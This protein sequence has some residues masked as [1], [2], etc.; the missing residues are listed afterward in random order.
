MMDLF[1]GKRI[2][3]SAIIKE[4]AESFAL[5]SNDSK[6]LN[7]LDTDYARI[8]SKEYYET[9]IDNNAQDESIIEYGIRTLDDDK[10][11]GFIMLHSIEWNNRKAIM[12]VG[13]GDK[14][15]R[16]CGYGSEA[17]E[18]ILRFAFMELNLNR[19]GLDVISDNTPAIECY[20]KAGFTVEGRARESVIR[21]GEKLDLIYMGILY[22]DWVKR[23]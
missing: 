20:Q 9:V 10:L 17:I 18:M 21:F 12:T 16:G 13:I 7:N 3:L 11:I 15:A 19:V 23:Q 1:I 5:W 4:D 6:Y 8:R 14:A 2:R 22:D